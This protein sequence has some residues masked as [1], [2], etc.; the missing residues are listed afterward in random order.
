M[1]FVQPF[2]VILLLIN[3]AFYC[4][5]YW[6]WT[7]QVYDLNIATGFANNVAVIANVKIIDL[8]LCGRNV[9]VVPP[10]LH[11]DLFWKNSAPILKTN[12]LNLTQFLQI[13]DDNV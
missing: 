2:F 8:L 9:L 1:A 12:K 5:N 3:E 11:R 10:V 7:L 13:N 6:I 4:S